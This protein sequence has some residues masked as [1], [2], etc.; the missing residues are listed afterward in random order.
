MIWKLILQCVFLFRRSVFF[1]DASISAHMS[2]SCKFPRADPRAW[3]RSESLFCK[4]P[5]ATDVLMISWLSYFEILE[6]HAL[7][8]SPSY[9]RDFTPQH[10]GWALRP[11]QTCSE[12]SMGNGRLANDSSGGWRRALVGVPWRGSVSARLAWDDIVSFNMLSN[13]LKMLSILRRQGTPM[14]GTPTT[15]W[16]HQASEKSPDLGCKTAGST[17]LRLPRGH[18]ERLHPKKSDL[19]YLLNLNCSE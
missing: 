2:P 17:L 4:V 6:T 8:N 5:V 3:I 15:A 13:V 14:R 18:T 19:I 11:A 12:S 16:I 9:S 1:T 7:A 10:I